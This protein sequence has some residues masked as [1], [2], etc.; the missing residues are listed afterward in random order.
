MSTDSSFET[1]NS[2]LGLLG[3]A[4]RSHGDRTRFGRVALQRGHCV[5][6]DLTKILQ[7]R[8]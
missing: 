7:R 6:H 1:A 8:S 4:T 2:Y 3:Q 5:P